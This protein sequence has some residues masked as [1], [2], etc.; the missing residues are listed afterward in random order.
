MEAG[1]IYCI[2]DHLDHSDA[3]GRRLLGEAFVVQALE[4]GSGYADG[5]RFGGTA[6]ERRWS[7][8]LRGRL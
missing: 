2:L 1:V 7:R 4:H 8:G 5:I 3:E 6:V